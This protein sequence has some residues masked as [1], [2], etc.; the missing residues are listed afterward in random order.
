MR[1]DDDQ[2]EISCCYWQTYYLGRFHRWNCSASLNHC[3]FVLKGGLISDVFF[4]F[5]F[6]SNIPKKVPNHLVS[7]LDRAQDSFWHLYGDIW[8]KAKNFLL[9]NHLYGKKMLP[10][11]GK[12]R[13][14]IL[15][16][17]ILT[18][19]EEKKICWMHENFDSISK[20]KK[21]N[22]MESVC[23]K[24]LRIDVFMGF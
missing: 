17:L 1:W 18:R 23:F 6:G 12:N 15:E 24:N 10:N 9:L 5:H 13:F 11:P 19:P 22:R 2:P 3:S 14:W 20:S 4:F 21:S 8:A 16:I 7:L